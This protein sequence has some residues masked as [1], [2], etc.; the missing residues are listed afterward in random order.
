MFLRLIRQPDIVFVNDS[1]IIVV[2]DPAGSGLVFPLLPNA[3]SFTGMAVSSGSGLIAKIRSE[4]PLVR[5]LA[6]YTRP[7]PT[8]SDGQWWACC[9]PFHDDRNP[10][11]WIN[12]DKNLCRCHVPG[13]LGHEHVMDVINVYALLHSLSNEQAIWALAARF[14]L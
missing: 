8:S 5:F 11:M 4:M 9:C 3:I 7:V 14:G 10:S 1:G 6:N 12:A 2:S 13:C